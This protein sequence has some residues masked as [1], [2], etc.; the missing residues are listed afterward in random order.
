MLAKTLPA[1][2]LLGLSS[3]VSFVA[4]ADPITLTDVTG[5]QVVLPKPAERVILADSRAIQALQ[6]VHPTKPFESIIAWDNALKAKAP[7]LGFL[8]F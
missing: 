1:L 7:D 4:Q 6:L 2:L 3:L 8:C 5:R